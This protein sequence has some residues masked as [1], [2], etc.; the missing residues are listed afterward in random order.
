MDAPE[1][2]PI[3]SDP[4]LATEPTV[5]PR[6]VRSDIPEN[7]YDAP[8]L[9]IV[10]AFSTRFVYTTEENEEGNLVNAS[11]Q[12]KEGIVSNSSDKPLVITVTEVNIPTQETS[13][14]QLVIGGGA[15]LHFGTDQGLKMISG[16]QITLHSPSHKDFIRII[17]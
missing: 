9:P 2:D 17:P 14:G 15:Q 5:S 12:V 1:P 10:F 6:A 3:P 16:D 8:E 11:K 4:V 13:Q 7:D